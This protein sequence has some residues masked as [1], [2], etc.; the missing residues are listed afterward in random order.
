MT[1]NDLNNSL[2]TPSAEIG[3]SL[4]AFALRLA[5]AVAATY[6]AGYETGA[7]VHRLNDRCAK[8]A[9]LLGRIPA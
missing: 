6:T 8:I 3:A 4:R 9:L 2:K 7:F 1:F 5:P